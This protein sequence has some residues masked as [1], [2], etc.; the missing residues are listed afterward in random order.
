MRDSPRNDTVDPKLLLSWGNPI[1]CHEEVI[2]SIMQSMIPLKRGGYSV[3]L[4]AFRF[5]FKHNNVAPFV[6]PTKKGTHDQN[7]MT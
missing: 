2:L 7:L 6:Q 5:F 4:G 3:S 1:K